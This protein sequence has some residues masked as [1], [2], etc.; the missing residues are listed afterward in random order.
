MNLVDRIL[1]RPE[2]E[3]DPPVV[4]D[5][6]ASGG[7]NPAWRGIRRHSICIAFDGDNQG[8]K[9]VPRASAAY[10]QLYVYNLLVT[11]E[12]PGSADFY[13]TRSATCSSLLPPNREQLSEWAFADR[14][15]VLEKRE[16]KTTNLTTILN[17]LGLERIDWFKSDS[18]GT[19]LR[20]FASLGNPILSRVLV[21]EFE[22]GILD[23]YQGED[24]LWQ[25]LAFMESHDFWMSDMRVKGSQCL[26]TDLMTDFTNLEKRF[27]PLFLKRSPGWGEIAY[28]NCFRRPD[29]TARDFLLGWV[30]AFLMKQ[31]GFALQL[32]AT[33]RERFDDPVFDDLRDR[34]ITMIRLSYLKPSAYLDLMGRLLGKLRRQI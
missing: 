21:A 8:L 22:P 9:K 19:D 28:L 18:Q 34:A 4:V 27:A 32:A 13:F 17:Q 6:G 26:R 11:P 12:G 20:L 29:F 23:A 7:L 2:F 25:V 15:E 30:F 3:H 33:A 16:V 31:Y 10:K 1:T 5:I 14:F 24:K